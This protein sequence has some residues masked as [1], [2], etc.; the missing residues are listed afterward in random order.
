MVIKMEEQTIFNPEKV[1]QYYGRT[2]ITESGSS[3]GITKEGRFTGRPSIEG[4]EI[5]LIAGF[6]N[7]LY[8][9]FRYYLQ[10]S[11]PELKRSKAKCFIFSIRRGFRLRR[12]ETP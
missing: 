2:F 4:A 7:E 10:Y 6:K 1:Q 8:P 12:Q 11:T 9:K 3:Y 5:M